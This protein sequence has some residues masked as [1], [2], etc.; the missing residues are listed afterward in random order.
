[1][2]FYIFSIDG[3][4]HSTLAE[5]AE[6][7]GLGEDLGGDD[8]GDDP[9]PPIVSLV[10][11]VK[12][13]R[14]LKAACVGFMPE[15][16]DELPPHVTA[17]RTAFHNIA[18]DIRQYRIK[19]YWRCMPPMLGR[20]WFSLL[21]T[22]GSFPYALLF[23][24]VA[25]ACTDEKRAICKGLLEAHACCLDEGFATVLTQLARIRSKGLAGV[26]KLET[27][28]RFLMSPRVTAI[29]RAWA[30][31][32]AVSVFDIECLN[33]A[34]RLLHSLGKAPDY[35]SKSAKLY[36]IELITAFESV[37]S[38]RLPDISTEVSDAIKA[39]VK[40]ANQESMTKLRPRRGYDH[41]TKA[42]LQYFHERMPHASRS[43]VSSQ[44]ARCSGG[45][46]DEASADN[47]AIVVRGTGGDAIREPRK[48]TDKPASFADAD[49]Q[50][51]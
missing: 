23:L 32:Q 5:V 16:P 27:E 2:L 46:S 8:D 43:S 37:N 33:A 24:I 7:F 45:V 50:C 19:H 1:M 31:C 36:C 29:I 39:E 38:R 11:S 35:A 3:R 9:D 42:G 40:Q 17:F 14:I 51:F 4:V 34:L 12:T 41:F 18:D 21:V 49:Q 10:R 15:E 6:R 25:S 26:A 30:L 48:K 13:R 47:A 44:T 28:I 22:Y 20:L